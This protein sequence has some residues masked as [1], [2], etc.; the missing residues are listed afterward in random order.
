M[1]IMVVKINA[2][3]NLDNSLPCAM[4]T[5]MLKE[6]GIKYVYY[7]DNNGDII[8]QKVRDLKGSHISHGLCNAIH[9]WWEQFKIARLPL[10]TA[11]KTFLLNK[12]NFKCRI[13][14]EYLT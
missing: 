5:H 6:F 14:P 11:Q 9:T 7:S 12:D 1:D 10:S 8:R 4:C 2:K 3:G 13:I